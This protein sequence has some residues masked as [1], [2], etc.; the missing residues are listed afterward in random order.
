[1][2]TPSQHTARD[3][4]GIL[5]HILSLGFLGVI[6]FFAICLALGLLYGAIRALWGMLTHP[7]FALC[8]IAVWGVLTWI[9]ALFAST[10]GISMLIAAGATLILG[11]FWVLENG[12]G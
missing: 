2:T 10:W 1:M 12:L 4:L 6:W 8:L 3:I 7:L 9:V 11:G 5:G